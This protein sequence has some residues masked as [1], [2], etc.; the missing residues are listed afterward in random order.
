VETTLA[1]LN[2]LERLLGKGTR[3]S[4]GN[5]QFVC[6]F[7][8]S[9]PP[10]KKKLEV[11]LETGQWGCFVCR[12]INGAKG[13]KVSTLLKKMEAPAEFFHELKIISPNDTVSNHRHEY[14]NAVLP[15]EFIQLYNHNPEGKLGT[16]KYNQATVFLQNRGIT[17]EDIIKYNIGYCTEGNY[18]DR[19]IIP[20]YDKN[21][22]LNYFVARDFTNNLPEKYKNP[23]V[24]SKDI[25]ALELFINWNA[26]II[27]VEGMF[28]AMTIKRNVIPLLGKVIHPPLMKKI[29]ESKVNRIY[30]CL[31]N[32]AQKEA[33]QYVEQLMGYGKEIYLVELDGKDANEVGFEAFFNLIEDV[34]PMTFQSL[35]SKKLQSL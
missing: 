10:G 19:I 18:A 8:V 15:K 28:D 9:N 35:M 16:I 2:L 1:L 20:S 14:D 32:D 3:K 5:Y 6:P 13:Q 30:I 25:I 22:N 31:D 4:R 17:E 27:L 21:G 29:M 33:M 11:N 7:H 26:P 34:E 23:G 24:S 12:N